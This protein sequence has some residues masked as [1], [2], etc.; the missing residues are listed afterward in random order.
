M[1]TSII[2][3]SS[4]IVSLLSETDKNHPIAL[5]VT[6]DLKNTSGSIIVPS[7]VFSET[8]NVIGRK[9]GHGVAITVGQEI[10]TSGIYLVLEANEKT[11]Q[12]AF[13]LFKAQPGSVSF[14]DCIVMAFADQF[15]TKNIFG[16][17]EAFKKNGYN[18]LGFERH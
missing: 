10:I 7:D 6:D 13:E 4:G 16:F 5:Q 15:N 11:R 3:D 9:I 8:L 17:D 14:T 2:A 12:I 18:R 1:N